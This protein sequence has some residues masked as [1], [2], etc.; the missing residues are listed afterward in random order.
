M[1]TLPTDCL[2]VGGGP[3]GSA[4]AETAK[5]ANPNLDVILL[6]RLARPQ[7]TCAGGVSWQW[8][9]EMG[10]K[11]P[12]HIIETSIDEVSVHGP[13]ED[14][15]ISKNDLGI[16]TLGWV[17]DRWGFDQWLLCKAAAAGAN[18]MRE[19]MFTDI[20]KNNGGWLIDAK[21]KD[22]P[23]QIQAKYVVDASGPNAVV[24]KRLGM[25]INERDRDI[26]VGLQWTIP[27]PE[28]IP[29]GRLEMWF[30]R[31][32][33]PDQ[34]WAVPTGYVWSF[35]TKHPYWDGNNPTKAGHYTRLG[36]GVDRAHNKAPET[37]AKQCLDYFRAANPDFA[38]PILSENGGLIPTG[39][40]LK[41]ALENVFLVGDAGRHVSSL[42]GGG[43]W[44]ARVAGQEA[45]RVIAKGGSD[46]DYE[47]GWRGRVGFILNVHYA[48]KSILYDLDNKQIDIVVK[49]LSKFKPQSANPVA[50]IMRAAKVVGRHP[51]LTAKATVRAFKS[52]V[53]R[54]STEAMTETV[55]D[56]Y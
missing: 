52:M 14:A 25:V 5:L 33:T 45:G 48:L 19:T 50:E 46:A 17:V 11:I 30:K 44:F 40:P 43:I 47:K 51:A 39:K 55:T 18:V 23:F 4:A 13:T 20:K 37:S 6:E 42:H 38:G 32:K 1:Q 35:A 15:T 16:E 28:K 49:E 2:V 53:E 10:L 29:L 54:P 22:G 7:G 41:N 8:C 24:A 31:D 36:I 27:L 12:E 3:G 56:A 9:E 26:H 21:N 34:P